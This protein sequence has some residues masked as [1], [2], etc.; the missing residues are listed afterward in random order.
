M[1]RLRLPTLIIGMICIVLT[2]VP[3]ASATAAVATPTEERFV[4][5]EQE[6]LHR[7]H[8]HSLQQPFGQLH[9]PLVLHPS[10][11][12][13]PCAAPA[14]PTVAENCNPGDDGWLV[15][16]QSLAIT[17]YAF[18]PSVAHGETVSLYVD[19][20]APTY[21]L[22]IYRTGFYGGKGGRLML[23]LHDR[24]GQDQPEC[25]HNHATGTLSCANWQL[26]QPVSIPTDWFSGIY[27]AKIVRNDTGEA[28]L[29]TFTVRD[30]VP[31]AEV[32]YQQSI[33]TYHAY[34]SFG[35]K[36]LYDQVGTDECRTDSG[37]RRALA[38][39]LKRPYAY[40]SD[41]L[42]IEHPLVFWLEQQ[43]YSM[44]Y[45]NNWDTHRAGLAEQNPLLQYKLFV[46]S[47]HDEYWSQSMRDA[48]E[49]ARDA[50]V[51]L[52]FFS[53]NVMYWRVRME[54]EPVSG[55]ADALI[56]TYKT[57]E[58]GPPDPQG[59]TSTWRDANGINAPENAL[60]G[61]MYIGDNDELDFP[62]RV[63]GDLAKDR[64]YRNTG[65]DQLP[66]DGYVD[67][68][69]DLIGWEWDAVVENG[70][71]PPG[72]QILAETPTYGILLAD[73]GYR[74]RVGRGNAHVT[75]YTA[76]SGA[77]VFAT[78]TNRWSWG[79]SRYEPDRRIQ[80]ITYNVLAD[81]NLQPATPAADLVLDGQAVA[82]PP[83]QPDGFVSQLQIPQEVAAATIEPNPTGAMVRWQIDRPTNA[84]IWVRVMPEIDHPMPPAD[85]ETH[86]QVVMDHD[87][88][89]FNLEPNRTYYYQMAARSPDGQV[90]LTETKSFQTSA[91]SLTERARFALKPLYRDARCVAE[92]YPLPVAAGGVLLI[93]ITAWGG[94]GIWRR[95][96]RRGARTA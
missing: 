4:H 68:G 56:V 69:Q 72:L 70:H 91:G 74:Y 21:D 13:D 59:P 86:N 28:S 42:E 93:G 66:P 55:D 78:G 49:E 54:A 6:H 61:V 15:E 7:N 18:P 46:S 87:L 96:Q 41:Y 22:L 67:I 38:V 58:N 48:V 73:A 3:L 90:F 10:L 51:H 8:Y 39:S 36:S 57:S 33:F 17:G 2:S 83:A 37:D 27:L 40:L 45:S 24:P 1:Q 29:M 14:N 77:I 35:G 65:L 9:Q 44:S 53:S 23:H 34:N 50:G 20:N 26:S 5:D 88:E 84:Q 16:T 76:P 71:T 52:A 75:R 19:T 63:R 94:W 12:G 95:W 85:A 32:L 80:Q 30:Q 31:A 47:G 92:R 79:L 81:M 43:G 64:I 25:L 82:V 89:V 62:L 60:V 11:Q